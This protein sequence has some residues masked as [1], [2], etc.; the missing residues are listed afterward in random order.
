MM[1]ERQVKR[2]LIPNVHL[3]FS[4][5][6]EVPVYGLINQNAAELSEIVGAQTYTYGDGDI[7][8]TFTRFAMP[9]HATPQELIKR[10]ND[11]ISGNIPFNETVRIQFYSQ[12]IFFSNEK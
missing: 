4:D 11:R 7:V 12:P 10:E 9:S 8:M 1:F 3:E 5:D 2:I 6:S